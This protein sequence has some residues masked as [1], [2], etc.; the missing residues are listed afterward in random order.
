M[1][2]TRYAQGTMDDCD[3]SFCL[4]AAPGGCDS[5]V[6]IDQDAF[7]SLAR[8]PRGTEMQYSK[9]G[10]ANGL[11]VFVIDG[12]LDIGRKELADGTGLSLIGQE[13]PVLK[14]LAPSRV[15]CIEVPL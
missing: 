6:E 13:S 11:H 10:D 12:R 7:V 8:L 4:I 3:G 15:L 5:V 1:T 2:P 9:Y 14:V